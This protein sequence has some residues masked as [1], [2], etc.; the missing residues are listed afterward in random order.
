MYGIKSLSFYSPRLRTTVEDC[1]SAA[2]SSDARDKVFL[3][4]VGEFEP[5]NSKAL[6]S[7]L[8]ALA[9]SSR[10]R[11]IILFFAYEQSNAC[12]IIHMCACRPREQ[13]QYIFFRSTEHARQVESF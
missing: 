3:S 8:P 4:Y 1:A 2:T 7:E 9:A 5:C 6:R 12:N 11:F 10:H 13:S